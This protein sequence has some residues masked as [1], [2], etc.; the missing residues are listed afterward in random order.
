MSV[1]K[2]S[3]KKHSTRIKGILEEIKR[4]FINIKNDIKDNYKLYLLI[5][6]VALLIA[7]ICF[8]IFGKEN[9]KYSFKSSQILETE[10]TYLL[11]FL[12]V[13]LL[14]IIIKVYYKNIKKWFKKHYRPYMFWLSVPFILMDIFTFIFG[15]NISYT[16]YHF[17]SPIFFT[18]AWTF[19]FVG[20]S[21]CF[22]RVIGRIIFLFFNILFLTLYLVN[23][24][25]YSMTRTFFDFSLME[26]ASEGT[27]YIIDALKACNIFVYITFIV[28]IVF[29]VNGFKKMPKIK[30]NNYKAAG[31]IVV[32]FII[33]HLL[34]PLT[35]GK[36]NKNLTW[37][38]WRNARNI[39]NSYNESNK[40]MKV[41]GF[42]EYSV[43]NFYIT[44]MRSDAEISEEDI[45]FLE[46]AFEKGKT[47]KN[48]YTGKLKGKNLILIQL[49]GTDSWLLN[50]N[51]T[52]TLY[53]MMN[54]GI[55]FSKH[56]SYY[57]GGGSTFNSE[58][59]VNTGF[60]TPLSYTRN[61]YSFNKNDFPYSLARLF[62][63]SGY[64]VNAFHMNYGEY[65]SRNV[66]YVNWGYDKYYGLLD[67]KKF[68]DDSFRL[69]RNLV[70]TEELNEKMFPS[71]G[72]FVDYIIAY[73]GHVPFDNTRETC[74]LLY[75]EDME[76]KKEA[77]ES[78][79]FV[80][81][82]EEECARRQ[83]GETD[84]MV[85]LIIENLKEKGLY[86]NTVIVVFADHY[87]YTLSDIS[88]LERYKNTSNNLVNNT[89]WFIWY[90]GVKKESVKKVTSQLN[91]LPTVLNLFGMKYDVNNYIGEDALHGNY[92][93]VAFFSDYSWYDGNVYVDGGI[94]TNGKKISS[95]KLV[96][97]NEYI[98]YLI[99]KNDLALKYNF[100]K[101]NSSD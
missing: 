65:Y 70:L 72:N 10:R 4:F 37:S 95:E 84:Y 68:S 48:R 97:K 35:L 53:K 15:I 36:P 55:N 1:K 58:F 85:Q 56:Y 12:G 61:A 27:P 20:L 45:R 46:S 75:E 29:I 42:F 11:I 87:L 5:L 8:L 54:E 28:I 74:M 38:S 64:Y 16:N 14:G 93:G 17:M 71:D 66:N 81:M 83:S 73:S 78:T 90:K 52:P 101:K 91:I 80:Q 6:L 99:K 76:K 86:D 82:S 23:N 32:I 3:T 43:R 44:Y 39:Y 50:K 19:L 60:I 59:A 25:Y 9:T 92:Q 69:D 2:K 98:N 94:V 88:V 34:I 31:I 33:L 49:E 7:N 22:K 13:G 18:I 30:N 41:S 47:H 51:D 77:G 26:S 67:I 89:P 100:F 62:K 63:D 57:N 21:L 79:E 24:V 96:E 40:S